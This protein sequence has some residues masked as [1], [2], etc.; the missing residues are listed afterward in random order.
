MTKRNPHLVIIGYVWPEAV[1]SA[2]G[3]RDEQLL[4]GFREAGWKVT[5]LSPAA[6]NQFSALLNRRGIPTHSVAAND[7]AFDG[8]IKSLKPDAV[9]FDRFV[10]E[11]Q[12]GWRVREQC[13]EALRIIDTQ[14][15]HFLRRAREKQISTA[16]QKFLDLPPLYTEDT[17]REIAAIY[18]ADLS[19]IISG[20]ERELL[21]KR[22]QLPESLL[23][24]H[25]FAYSA[26]SAEV[27]GFAERKHCVFLGNYRHA[28]NY[29]GALWFAKAVWPLVR[30]ADPSL[31]FHLYGS[32]APRE[33]S[34]LHAPDR[35]IHFRGHAPDQYATLEKYRVNLA[36]VR[37]GAGLKGKIADG[38]WKGV[39]AVA[40]AIGA[41]GMRVSNAFG[42]LEANHPGEIAKAVVDLHQNAELWET[43]RARGRSILEEKFSYDRNTQTL[44]ARIEQ[45]RGRLEE[46]REENFI[47]QML[48]HHQFKSTTYFSRWIEL[49][50]QIKRDDALEHPPLPD[51]ALS[52]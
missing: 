40:T 48:W 17:V 9:L 12:F 1:S 16:P 19:L 30:K 32:Y 49:K 43:C 22:F 36:P 34:E 11:E 38:W 37:F 18:R 21:M 3:V 13:P 27:P 8:L 20:F 35:G 42:G 51:S 50:N 6:S 2:A 4:Q 15:L 10:T 29:D 25:G 23:L 14:D 44:L 47:G 45:L 31:E 26:P 46:H 52:L 5:F 24:E 41:E 39:P 7:P 33:I 28:P